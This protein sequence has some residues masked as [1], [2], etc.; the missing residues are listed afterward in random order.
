[1]EHAKPGDASYAIFGSDSEEEDLASRQQQE[2]GEEPAVD[3]QEEATEGPDEDAEAFEENRYTKTCCFSSQSCHLV[4]FTYMYLFCNLDLGMSRQTGQE[5]ADASEDDQSA[6]QDE[7]PYSQHEEE[8]RGPPL[9][10]EAPLVDCPG[11][12][13]DT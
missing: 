1:M 4:V 9:K 10:I 6:Q 3:H 12:N 8:D 13:T 2:A 5:Y 11:K 7:E